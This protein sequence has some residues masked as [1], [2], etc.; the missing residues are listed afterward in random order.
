M[1][2]ESFLTIGTV[3]FD[4]V[5]KF[6]QCLLQTHADP[7]FPNNYAEFRTSGL[8]LGIFKPQAAHEI[9]FSKPLGS[10]FSLCLEI[11]NLE[12]RKITIVSPHL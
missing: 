10:G 2:K 8:K 1:I 5:V 4:Q 3:N 9:E 7:Y 6:Y 12:I 11:E